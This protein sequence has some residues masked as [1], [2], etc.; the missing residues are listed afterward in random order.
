MKINPLLIFASFSLVACSSSPG[1]E[2]LQE[3]IKNQYSNCNFVTV[4]NIK[5]TNGY[6]SE[7]NRYIIEYGYDLILDNN[8]LNRIEETYLNIDSKRQA[9]QKKY[10]ETQDQ[11]SAI[12]KQIRQHLNIKYPEVKFEDIYNSLSEDEKIDRDKAS[13]IAIEK[14]RISNRERDIAIRNDEELIKMESLISELSN[15]TSGNHNDLP[16][17]DGLQELRRTFIQGC[18]SNYALSSIRDAIS[19]SASSLITGKLSEKEFY[20]KNNYEIKGEIEFKKT[21]NGWVLN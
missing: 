20:S 3:I 12:T 15:S 10:Q 17:G 13:K 8:E 21:E 2:E 6:E 5:K 4:D 16:K 18:T 11:I 19:S 1:N 9:I 14:L 7:K